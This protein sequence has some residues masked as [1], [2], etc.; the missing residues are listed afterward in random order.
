MSC[1]FYFR[2]ARLCD[3]PSPV[4]SLLCHLRMKYDWVWGLFPLMYEWTLV[5]VGQ[6][7]SLAFKL[8][9]VLGNEQKKLSGD[10]SWPRFSPLLA[11]L[12]FTVILV[13][14]RVSSLSIRW[15][16]MACLALLLGPLKILSDKLCD[17]MDCLYQNQEFDMHHLR[18]CLGLKATY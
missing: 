17:V 14:A 2:H 4:I 8:L 18:E 16:I 6:L 12:A 5:M 10:P 7:C 15:L 3:V 9:I 13:G 11:L 1:A